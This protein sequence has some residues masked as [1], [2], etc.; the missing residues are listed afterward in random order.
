MANK[1]GGGVVGGTP[2]RAGVG[3]ASPKGAGGMM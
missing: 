3:A 1:P 2:A